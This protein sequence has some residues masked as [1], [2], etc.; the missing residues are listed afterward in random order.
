M[1]KF[2]IGLLVGIVVAVLGSFI[3]LMAIG[4]AFSNK[5]PTIAGDSVLV[6]A[7]SGDV[8]EAAPVEVPIP[9]LQSESSPTV[10]D[11]WTSLHQAATDNRIRA[12]VIQPE[13]V[14]AGWG[15]LQE[16]RH[17][18]LEF[19]KSGKPVYAFLQ[20]SGS[21][22]YYLASA[23][24]K[25]FI[26]PDDSL[27]VKGFLLQEMYFKNTLDKLGVQVQVDHMGKYKDAGEYLHQKRNDSG[28]Q[29]SSE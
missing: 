12:L 20:A 26:S 21:R 8:P 9:F 23:A 25:I 1:W 15:K 13:S 29:G 5:Q 3:V 19:K 27:E 6:L 17:E 10:R 7:L 14:V 16:I 2:F 28:D 11:L 4:R 24:D 18:L 22:E